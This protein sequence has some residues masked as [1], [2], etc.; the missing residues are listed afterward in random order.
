MVIR[1]SSSWVRLLDI[2]SARPCRPETRISAVCR[3]EIGVGA[4]F[5]DTAVL[6]HHDRVCCH[7]L[8][9]P[10]RHDHRGP[11]LG[12]CR[13]GV[14]EQAGSA[15]AGLRGRFVEYCDRGIGQDQPRQCELLPLGCTERMPVLPD[16]CVEA[17]RQ[18]PHPVGSSD[19]IEGVPQS[20]VVGI[21]V[22][23]PQIVGK[24]AGTDVDVLR[25]DRDVPPE[26]VGTEIT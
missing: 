11:A 3:H 15:T 7:G 18:S 4:G 24:R 20:G 6:E 26:S 16:A 13:C 5:H 19:P 1:V 8:C 10:V 17:L 22:R 14:F 9:Q 21:R 25:E 2:C 12:R 23:E